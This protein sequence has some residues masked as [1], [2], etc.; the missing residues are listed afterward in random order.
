[1]SRTDSGNDQRVGK[2]AFRG[3][4]R[5]ILERP[6]PQ[7]HGVFDMDVGKNLRT[8]C[9]GFSVTQRVVGVA[10]DQ[11]LV[12][13]HRTTVD[14]DPD[15]ITAAHRTERKSRTGVIAK[16]IEAEWQRDRGTYRTACGRH[17]GNRFRCHGGFGERHIAEVL[18][19][20]GMSTPTFIRD[21]IRHRQLQNFPQT[22]SKSRR[23]GKRTQVNDS[24]QYFPVKVQ[25]RFH[26]G[27][28]GQVSFNFR[29]T[30]IV[31]RAAS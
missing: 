30:L 5:R 10:F 14:V 13:E 16:N 28:N 26:D 24:D 31:V 8:G 1:M 22:A 17:G 18:D 21:S 11:S 25:D 6:I 12:R 19:E 15:E 27:R 9:N 3:V 7:R 20:H 4:P 2:A 23:P 29:G